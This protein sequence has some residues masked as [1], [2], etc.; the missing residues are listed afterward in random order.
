MVSK[1]YGGKCR[2]FRPFVTQIVIVGKTAAAVT[3]QSCKGMS[4]R[5]MLHKLFPWL[6]DMV[7]FLCLINIFDV[8]EL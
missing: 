7:W 6:C 5:V 4:P 8:I 1:E 2:T 3:V